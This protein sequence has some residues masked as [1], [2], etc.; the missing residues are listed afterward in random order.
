MAHQQQALNARGTA[1]PAAAVIDKLSLTK[2][3]ITQTNKTKI[4][5]LVKFVFIIIPHLNKN[6]NETILL[7]DETFLQQ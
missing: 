5:E 3:Y 6:G 7:D 2:R 4:L 1:K